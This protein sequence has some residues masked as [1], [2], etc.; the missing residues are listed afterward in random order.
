MR[1]ILAQHA[2][3]VVTRQQI[4]NQVGGGLNLDD[5]HY[6]RIVIRKLRENRLYCLVQ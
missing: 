4:M 3:K 1:E 2:G 5:T 6:L